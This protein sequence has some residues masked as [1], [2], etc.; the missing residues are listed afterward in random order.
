M[1]D[2][3]YAEGL[4][5]R[6]QPVATAGLEEILR[7]LT[8]DDPYGGASGRIAGEAEGAL[9]SALRG[10]DPAFIQQIFDA[11]S[12]PMR[13]EFEETTLPGIRESMV[14]SGDFWSTGRANLETDARL[15]F[16]E[17]MDAMLANLNLQGR[18]ES[19]SAIPM[20]EQTA[21]IE[22]NA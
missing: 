16:Q 3:R 18:Q 14:S 21:G 6:Q 22:Q 2:I 9:T 10:M 19:L 8:T 5:P 12:A 7:M 17:Q 11:Q 20:A 13:R 1:A 15:K 4:D